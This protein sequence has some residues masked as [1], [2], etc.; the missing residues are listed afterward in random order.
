MR[1]WEFCASA[2]K[3]SKAIPPVATTTTGWPFMVTNPSQRLVLQPARLQETHICQTVVS[4]PPLLQETHI[5]QTLISQPTLLQE[6]HICQAVV[7]QPTRLARAILRSNRW[8]RKWYRTV[9]TSTT[10]RELLVSLVRCSV[11]LIIFSVLRIRD[12]YP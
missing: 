3:N 12:V 4:Q 2:A 7:S 9:T 1:P 11:F 5:C 10:S 6:T 8:K